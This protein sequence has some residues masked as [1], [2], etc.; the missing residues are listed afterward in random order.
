MYA[1]PSLWDRYSLPPTYF[2]ALRN[3]VEVL[4]GQADLA[5][6]LEDGLATVAL[7]EATERSIATGRPVDPRPLMALA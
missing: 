3:L 5:V 2:G 7:I 6:T 1:R 4:D